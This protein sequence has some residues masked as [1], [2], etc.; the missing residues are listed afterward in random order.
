MVERTRASRAGRTKQ[1]ARPA[2]KSPMRKRQR[3]KTQ[4]QNA[5]KLLDAM[6]AETIEVGLDNL[7]SGRVAKA[8]GL[9]TGALY[10]RYENA[11]EMLIALWQH[12]VC[13]P[14]LQHLRDVVGFVQGTL[15]LQHPVT[16]A[17]E[18]PTPLLRLGAEFLVVAQRNDTLSEVITP[19]IVATLDYLGLNDRTD[20]L[21]GAVIMVGASAGLGTIFRSFISSTNPG[22]GATLTSLRT[23]AARATPQQFTAPRGDIAPEPINTGNPVRDD[24]L[25]SAK[26]VVARVGFKNATVTRIARRAGFS[27][28]AIYQLWPDK[29]T[30]LDEAINAVL[31]L[32]YGQ[33]S[34]A[35]FA[36]LTDNR[37]DFGFTDS[38]YFGMMPARRARLDFRLE[39]IIASRHR[40]ATRSELQKFTRSADSILQSMFPKIPHAITAQIT[41]TEQALGYGF[42]ALTKYSPQPQRLDYFSL[43]SALAK[44]ARL[45]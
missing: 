42:V 29:E 32:D 18:K 17:V 4:Q 25:T 38:W 15:P 14:F 12:R 10:S 30:M 33:S 9:T 22:W 13:V 28:S 16:R 5:E 35:K 26:R 3:T 23:A 31:V 24:L 8:A 20:P 1:Q 45:A 37:G 27:T 40:S 36:A 6:V 19:A 7:Q 41:A 44:V 11:D 2:P 43:M 39:C 21:A 34:R